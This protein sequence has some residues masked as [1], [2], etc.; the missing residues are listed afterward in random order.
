MNVLFVTAEAAPF[1]KI[2]GLGDVVGSLPKALRQHGVDARVV[3]PFYGFLDYQRFKLSHLFSYQFART[4]GT[5]RCPCAY[6]HVYDDVPFY[7][8]QSWPQFGIEAQVY[9]GWEWDTPRFIFL[10]RSRWPAAWE[11]EDCARVGSRMSFTSHD[12]H[13]GLLP[14]LV[15]ISRGDP[16]WAHVGHDDDHPQY[17]LSRRYAGGWM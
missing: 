7:F 15:E 1:A 5:S 11:L 13:T 8:V 14:F 4:V 6:R 3:M 9:G 17:G 16:N 2:G 12:W 10:A